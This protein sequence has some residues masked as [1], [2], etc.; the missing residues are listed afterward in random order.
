MQDA[1]HVG[2]RVGEVD[3]LELEGPALDLLPRRQLLQ[4]RV[5][6]LVLVELGAHH[7]DR[8]QAAVD[9]RRH[10]DL[11]QHVGQGADV[12]LVAVGEDDRLDVVGAV[13][14]V[15]EV[16]QDEVD[17]VHLGGREHQPGVDD[18]DPAVVLDHGHVLADLAEAA[19]GQHSQF[20]A[21]H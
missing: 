6:E 2:D 8:Q 12:V 15:G 5:G 20:L 9:H 7:P 19:Q 17:A 16:G 14:Q 11:A 18:D 1:A 3:Q 4:R 10:A 13:A 21:W